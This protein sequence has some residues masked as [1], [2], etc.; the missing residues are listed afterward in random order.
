MTNHPRRSKRT[1]PYLGRSP[2]PDVIRRT[3]EQAGQ[4]PEQAAAV[5][6]ASASA[7]ERW[8]ADGPD[9]RP[10]HPAIWDLYVRRL[11]ELP[12]IAYNLGRPDHPMRHLNVATGEMIDVGRGWLLSRAGDEDEYVEIVLAPSGALLLSVSG[13]NGRSSVWTT[14]PTVARA[15]LIDRAETLAPTALVLAA[16]R[17]PPLADIETEPTG[18]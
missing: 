17:Y 10:L 15:W 12:G 2:K 4:T 14:A 3:R 9:G 11:N 5:V 13:P 6:G 7:W 8:E 1:E 18:R 16:R